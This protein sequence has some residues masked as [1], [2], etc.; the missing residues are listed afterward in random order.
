MGLI[1]TYMVLN[2][3]ISTWCETSPHTCILTISPLSVSLF[4]MVVSPSSKSHF[5]PKSI[6]WFPLEL[7]CDCPNSS[8]HCCQYAL[9]PCTI[10]TPAGPATW[11]P[12]TN[13]PIKKTFD[14]RDLHVHGFVIVIL[15]IWANYQVEPSALIP[16]VVCLKG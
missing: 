4:H 16:I 1:L 2:L 5:Q 15:L 9:V 10:T 8:S 11:P 14:T 12:C 13:S 7:N 3:L 6:Q